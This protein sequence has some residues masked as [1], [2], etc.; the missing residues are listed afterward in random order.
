M[1]NRIVYNHRVYFQDGMMSFHLAF[2]FHTWWKYASERLICS[3]YFFFFFFQRSWKLRLLCK[4]S[5]LSNTVDQGLSLR[6]LQILP[7]LVFTGPIR[8]PTFLLRLGLLPSHRMNDQGPSLW[9]L[10]PRL[11][12]TL[13]SKGMGS[14]LQSIESCGVQ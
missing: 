4:F 3:I 2:T 13:S 7:T 9:I 10:L 1:S 5:I 14:S 8:Y 11:S 12:Q 6:S